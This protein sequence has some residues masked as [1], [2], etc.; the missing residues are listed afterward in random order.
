MQAGAVS[1]EV[2]LL[3]NEAA[4]QPCVLVRSP[5]ASCISAESL[6]NRL[7]NA[8]KAT[9]HRPHRQVLSSRYQREQEQLP[10][11]V[12][13]GVLSSTAVFALTANMIFS[14]SFHT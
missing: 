3:G 4:S 10:V 13:C 2:R 6:K 14:H 12:R 5:N 1:E 8:R 11:I 7:D 9:R